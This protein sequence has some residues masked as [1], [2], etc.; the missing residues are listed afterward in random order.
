MQK[1]SVFP[2]CIEDQLQTLTWHLEMALHDLVLV[3][4]FGLIF[5][6]PQHQDFSTLELLTFWAGS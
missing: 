2:C 4:S 1:L 5:P 3:N 6:I